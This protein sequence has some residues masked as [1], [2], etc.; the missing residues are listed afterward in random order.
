MSRTTR[1]K[2]M[3]VRVTSIT[4]LMELQVSMEFLLELFQAHRGWSRHHLLDRMFRVQC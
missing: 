3:R 1:S 4:N 2:G